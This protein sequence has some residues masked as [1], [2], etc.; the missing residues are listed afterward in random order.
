[1]PSRTHNLPVLPVSSREW[2]SSW[3]AFR[4]EAEAFLRAGD[5]IVVLVVL[6][7]QGKGSG[8]EVATA[9]AHVWTMR[10]GQAI[11]V[12]A[13]MNRAKALAAAGILD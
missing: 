8:A 9:T 6:H 10:R 13:Y 2:L 7:G 4:L 1:M 12:E 3:D 11:R 5:K